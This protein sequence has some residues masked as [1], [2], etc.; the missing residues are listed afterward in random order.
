MANRSTKTTN[1]YTSRVPACLSSS[2]FALHYTPLLSNESRH[3]AAKGGEGATGYDS[4][5]IKWVGHNGC[6]LLKLVRIL[7]LPWLY[8][9]NGVFLKTDDLFCL[10]L[11]QYQIFCDTKYTEL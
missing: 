11:Y 1:Q 9:V 5:K 3:L 10:S 2:L 4:P 6:D 7:G 8:K